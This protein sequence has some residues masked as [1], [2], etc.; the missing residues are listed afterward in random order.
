MKQKRINDSN[1]EENQDAN[2]IKIISNTEKIEQK[3]TREATGESN[4]IKPK[5]ENKLL[6]KVD[7]K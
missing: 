4:K 5:K 1:I 7:R 6:F 2:K 3:T